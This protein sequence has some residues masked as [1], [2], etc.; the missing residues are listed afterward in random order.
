MLP[1]AISNIHDAEQKT[2]AN[3]REILYQVLF[4]MKK[5]IM[6]LKHVVKNILS[7]QT[8]PSAT[9]LDKTDTRTE[10]PFVEQETEAIPALPVKYKE[11]PSSSR[12]TTPTKKQVEND[13][14]DAT[15]YEEQALS[16]EEVEKDMIKRA[17]ERHGG[18][19]KLAANDLKISERTLYR[20]IKEYNLE[21][22]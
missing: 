14:L 9:N 3:E 6:D 17:L 13:I 18:K 10:Y 1:V 2:F 22:L 16:L 8:D 5:D 15:E 20:K 21:N 7:G 11:T 4:D 19:R 12:E